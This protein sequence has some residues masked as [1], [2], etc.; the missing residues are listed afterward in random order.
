MVLIE[1]EKGDKGSLPWGTDQRLALSFSRQY[2]FGQ[3]LHIANTI[4]ALNE[5]IFEPC[6]RLGK[7]QMAAH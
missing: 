6:L 1:E 3:P 5:Q 7:Q 2:V 4:L